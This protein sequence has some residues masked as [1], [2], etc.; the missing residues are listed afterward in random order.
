MGFN[1][2]KATEPQRT[3]SY[4]YHLVTRSSWNSIDWPLNDEKLRQPCV[5]SVVPYVGGSGE[6]NPS[7][8]ME[9]IFFLNFQICHN[10]FTWKLNPLGLGNCSVPKFCEA[11]FRYFCSL[12]T[13]TYDEF[14]PY[15]TELF[16]LKKSKLITREGWFKVFP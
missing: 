5:F 13:G 15:A 6:N 16:M 2:L 9:K 4:F 11:G 8:D 3:D 7:K 14:A 10:F 12:F 1:C